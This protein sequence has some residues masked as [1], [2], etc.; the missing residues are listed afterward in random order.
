[1]AIRTELSL[2]LPN[3]PGALAAVCRVLADERVRIS[4]MSLDGTGLLRLL[5]DNH[6][7]GAG[8]LRDR[9]HTITE[10]EVIA[11]Q[12]SSTPGSLATVLALLAD[13]G[14]NVEY[15]YASTPEAGPMSVAVIGV[16]DAM[17]AAGAAGL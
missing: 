13:A 1:M 5:L 11:V 17:R 4:A 2:R 16:D 15:A 8:V 14:V 9:R 6:V 12:V 3:S 7:R 10:R